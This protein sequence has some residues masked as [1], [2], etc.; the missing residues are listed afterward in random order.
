M[1][2]GWG[3][4]VADGIH[5]ELE[6]VSRGAD[7]MKKEMGTVILLYVNWWYEHMLLWVSRSASRSCSRA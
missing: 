5:F 1:Q 4:G 3:H 7:P 2:V 6:E